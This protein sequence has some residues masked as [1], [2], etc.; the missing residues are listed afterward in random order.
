M[1]KEKAIQAMQVRQLYATLNATLAVTLLLSIILSVTLYYAVSASALGSWLLLLLAVTALRFYHSAAY[2][3]APEKDTPVGWLIKFRLG[4]IGSGIAWGLAGFLVDPINQPHLMVFLIFILVGLTAGGVISYS[5]DAFIAT[6]FPL[7]V[8]MPL[9]IHLLVGGDALSMS[10]G[11]AFL[12][13]VGF[14]VVYV[15]RN[16]RIAMEN[17]TLRLDTAEREERYR[18]V[19]ANSPVGIY[20]FDTNLVINYCNESLARILHT[21]VDRLVGLDS[22]LIKDQSPLPALRKALLGENGYYE[23]YYHSTVSGAAVWIALSSAPVRDAHGNITGGVAIVQ[24]VSERHTLEE[25]VR[26]HNQY[27]KALINAMAGI[28]LLL[29]RDGKILAVNEHALKTL[30]RT[31]EE[32]MGR[33]VFDLLPLDVSEARRAVFQEVIRG[34]KVTTA[35]DVREGKIIL[36]TLTPI[37]DEKGDVAQISVYATDVTEQ[38]QQE[39]I[40]DLW[41]ELNRKILH[42]VPLQ[43]VLQDVCRMMVKAFDLLLVWAGEKM[44]DGSIAVRAGSAGIENYEEILGEIGVRWDKAPTGQ[45]PAGSAIRD[46]VAQYAHVDDAR[47]APWAQSVKKHGIKSIICVP[48][49]RGREVFGVLSGYSQKSHHFDSPMM[50]KHIDELVDKI[51][52]A[53]EM[54]MRQQRTTLLSTALSTASNAVMI[55]NPDGVIE[56]VNPAFTTLSG[57]S[58]PELIGNRP[59]ILKSGKQDDAFYEQLWQTILSGQVWSRDTTDRHKNGALYTV[60]QT[61]TPI[62][63]ENGKITH[64]VAIQ[65]DVTAKINTQARFQYIATHDILTGLPNRG[66]FFEQ[67]NHICSL[68]R[69]NQAGVALLFIDLDGF[70]PVN[71]LHGH[72]IGDM[73]LSQ[74]AERLAHCVRDSDIVARLGGDEFTATLF[75][76]KGEADI[77]RIAE[78]IIAELSRPFELEGMQIQ[79]GASIGIATVEP[80]GVICDDEFV[81]RADSAMYE[82]KRAGKNC[83]R[84]WRAE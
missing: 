33:V 11:V 9:M 13:Y 79:V 66:L 80:G 31:E 1:D 52:I 73:L 38:R 58:S 51:R 67:L 21:E 36:S 65:E 5:V 2:R 77:S 3:R 71:D 68:A 60:Q 44:P 34:R 47:I 18:L 19:L 25:T 63:D 84:F 29:S 72:R 17:I 64:F 81:E 57:Y 75:D 49:F 74:V 26:Q 43:E 83:Y 7:L 37:F 28:S 78:K 41:P 50:R 32:A 56:W 4:A 16:S 62:M 82:A 48:L 70:K 23:G 27:I 54:S 12:L 40:E 76:I 46:G 59:S 14:I 6:S 22:K 10:M 35:E 55:T 24:D 53:L 39:A 15:K 69:R 20:Y 42:G 61:I 8:L 45:G 30:N